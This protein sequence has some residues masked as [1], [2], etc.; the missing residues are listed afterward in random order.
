MWFCKPNRPAT[1][2][3]N[4]TYGSNTVT[5]GSRL[6]DSAI[7]TSCLS[8]LYAILKQYSNFGA[9]KYEIVKDLL[10]HG[11][12]PTDEEVTRIYNL[13]YNVDLDDTNEFFTKE[14]Y[15]LIHEVSNY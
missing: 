13:C 6:I 2:P 4:D 3:Q 10:S 15:R 8:S 7:A 14:I 12:S 9:K 1:Y 5:S 11:I